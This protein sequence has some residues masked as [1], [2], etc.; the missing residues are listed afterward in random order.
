MAR[1]VIFKCQHFAAVSDNE[2]ANLRVGL[3][4]SVVE[5]RVPLEKKHGAP[6]VWT[7]HCL[8]RGKYGRPTARSSRRGPAAETL[9]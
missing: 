3:H 9:A 1:D 8:R 7:P 2:L 4:A 6:V 5:R